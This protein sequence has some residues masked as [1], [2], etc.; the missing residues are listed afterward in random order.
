MEAN[1]IHRNFTLNG[2]AFHSVAE[3]LTYSASLSEELHLFLTDWFS[4]TDSISIQTSG[5]TG[6]P[7][8]I[9]LKKLHIINSA[10]TTGAYFKLPKKTTALLCLP[11]AYVAGKLMV[12]R[13]LVLG[14]Q[15]DYV[16]PNSNPLAQLNKRYQFSAMVPLQ[17][18]NSLSKLHLIDKLIIGGAPISYQLEQQLQ[19]LQTQ[20]FATYGMTETI[21]HIAVKKITQCTFRPS[22]FEILPNVSISKTENDCLVIRAPKVA[23]TTIF[24]NDVVQLVSNH[25]FKWLGRLDLVIN[26]GGIKL[27]PESIEQ[28]LNAII[29]HR[30]FVA[31]IPDAYLGE[32]L[33]LIIESNPFNL[34]LNSVALTPFETPKEIYFIDKFVETATGKVQRQKT[35]LKIQTQ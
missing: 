13:A 28:K 21:T 7:K 3:L 10:K 18:Q 1:K 30:F 31:G 15:L 6:K 22:F 25:Q 17:V 16:A 26:S 20:I 35:L 24:T 8:P 2:C 23:D 4:K 11:I 12:V 27:H 5:S 19:Q 29:S 14:W 9:V 33:V 32:K 34:Q